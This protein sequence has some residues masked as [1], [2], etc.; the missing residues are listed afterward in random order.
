M[1]WNACYWL[2]ASITLKHSI[3]QRQ[4]ASSSQLII[5]EFQVEHVYCTVCRIP[6]LVHKGGEF[7]VCLRPDTFFCSQFRASAFWHYLEEEGVLKI[8]WANFGKYAMKLG[9]DGVTW[10]GSVIG[11]PES[12]RKMTFTRPISDAEVLLLNTEWNFQYEKGKCFTDPSTSGIIPCF[13]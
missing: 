13:D 8:D 1:R 10:E 3:I 5:E 6:Q 2:L 4:L 9:S 12:W 11:K 7:E